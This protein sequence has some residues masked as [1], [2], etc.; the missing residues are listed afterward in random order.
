MIFADN[1]Q[2]VRDAELS[3]LRDRTPWFCQCTVYKEKDGVCN[4]WDC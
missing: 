2:F 4:K 3:S 1:Y